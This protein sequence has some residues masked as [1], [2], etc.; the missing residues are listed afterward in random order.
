MFFVNE[1]LLEL[2][3]AHGLEAALL[4]DWIIFPDSAVRAAAAIVQEIPQRTGT[5]AQLTVRMEVAPGTTISESFAG[6]GETRDSAVADGFQN[7]A[8]NSFHVLL[9][10]FFQP[11]DE[12]VSEDEWQIG[13]TTR[14]VIVG[15]IGFRGEKNALV[16]VPLDWIEAFRA[17]LANEPLGPEVHWVRLY[18]AQMNGKT[19]ACEVLLDNEVW[20]EQQA[21]LESFA[22][23]KSESFYSV[24]LFLVIAPTEPDPLTPEGAVSLAAQIVAANP[25][26]TDDELYDGLEAASV[27]PRLASRAVNFT[28]TAW[29]RVLLD[30]MGIGFSADYALFDADGNVLENG[31]IARERC[32]VAATRLCPRYQGTPAFQRLALSSADVNA[33]NNALQNGSSPENLVLLPPCIFAEPPTDAG[34]ERAQQFM[35]NAASRIKPSAAKEAAPPEKG[36][37]WWKFWER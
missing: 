4:D 21:A 37:T 3:R 34:W 12:Q 19:S 28:Q 36:G 5:L 11:D 22:W 27:P 15:N 1:P 20:E 30:G 32:F 10:S 31:P 16:D 2:F 17:R 8:A 33:V 18:Y 7:F 9:K 26:L 24:R 14:R 13:E 29:G 25:D 6:L 23:P 35:Q